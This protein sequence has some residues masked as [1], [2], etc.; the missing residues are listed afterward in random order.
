MTFDWKNPD[1]VPVF[2]ERLRRLE[3]IRA[4]VTGERLAWLRAYYRDNPADFINDWGCTSDPRNAEVGLPVVV[5]FLLFP[6]QREFCSWFMERWQA[7]EPGLAEK[8][9]DFGLSWLAV[10]LAATLCLFRDDLVFGF[11]SRK[12]DLVD[13]AGDPKSLFWKAR[14]FID[15]LPAEFVGNNRP[16]SAHMR[17]EFPAT[18]SIMAGEAGDNIGRGDRA[19][20]YFVDEAAYVERPALIEASLSAT[21]NCRIDI[22]SANGMANPFAVKRHAG[23]ISLFTAHWRDDPRKDD[24]WYAKQCD[25]LDEVTVAQEIDINYAASTTGIVI[26]AVWANACVDAHIKLGIEPTGA[27]TG[28]YDVADEGPD[29]NALAVGHGI[30]VE[31]VDEWSGKGSDIFASVVHA[32]GLCDE[33]GLEAMKYDAD[34]MGADVRGNARVINAE[35]VAA[36]RPAILVTAYRG[37]GEVFAPEKEDVKGRK[38]KDYFLN[39]KA[40][41][42]FGLR[43]RAYKTYRAVVH[44]DAFD[45]DEIVSFSSGMP[46]LGALLLEL[47][48]ATYA[49][50][51]IGKMVINKKPDGTKSPNLADAVVILYGRTK[52]PAM[53]IAATALE[54]T[55]R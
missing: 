44:G 47:S 31:R 36:G 27:R 41:N 14:K 48:Q 22:S 21:T 51:T 15:G 26:P 30:L 37:S 38:N 29:K 49:P 45:P 39:P 19:S 55:A 7:R 18:G 16:K 40:Q 5:P 28:A 42:Y 17:I 3:M 34:G 23:K 13:R 10:S 32:F 43:R 9:R 20:A 25:E 52:R 54:E 35:R 50:N 53:R 8:S 6:K 46:N 33:Y 4:D 11:G 24:A 12:E 2:V 1:Y